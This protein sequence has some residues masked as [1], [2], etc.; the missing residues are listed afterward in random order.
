[1]CAQLQAGQKTSLSKGILKQAPAR[2]L[3]PAFWHD[4]CR[5]WGSTTDTAGARACT[6]V[7]GAARHHCVGCNT[8]GAARA[9]LTSVQD[10]ELVAALFL[11][12]F[13]SSN[14][15]LLLLAHA[16]AASSWRPGTCCASLKRIMAQPTTPVT[17]VKAEQV[18]LESLEAVGGVAGVIQ[19]A[20]GRW[21]GCQAPGGGRADFFID[22]REVRSRQEPSNASFVPC[23]MSTWHWV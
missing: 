12:L 6:R 14:Q 2:N 15:T 19:T 21:L 20:G 8:A 7:R 9:L 23:S 11:G 4:I 22:L 1:M 3:T 5:R 16:A 10:S 13:L 17:C 18:P